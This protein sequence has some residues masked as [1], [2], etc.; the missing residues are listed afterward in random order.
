M[1]EYKKL[2]RT[3]LNR[4]AASLC[5]FGAIIILS[6]FILAS[7]ETARKESGDQEY[8]ITQ[9]HYGMDAREMERSVAIPLEDALS[10]IPGIN[11]IITFSENGRVRCYIRFRQ[12]MKSQR[13]YDA[14][15]EAAQRVYET[16]PPSAQRPELSSSNE[17]GIPVWMGALWDFPSSDFPDRIIKPVLE[18]IERIAEVEISGAGILEI[19]IAPDP[20]KIAALGISPYHLASSLQMNDGF[21]SGGVIRSDRELI[22]VTV[23][24]RYT[25]IDSLGEALIPINGGAIRLRDIARIIEAERES[26]TISRLDGKKTAI[27]SITASSG[28]NLSALSRRIKQKMDSLA[29]HDFEFKILLDRG[30]EETSTFRSVLFAALASSVL[31]ALTAFILIRKKGSSFFPGLI[32]A[33]SIPLISIISAAF[34]SRLGFPLDRKLLAGLSIGIGAAADAVL[35]SAHGFAGI[36]DFWNGRKTLAL[37]SIPLI[38]AAATTIAALFPLASFSQADELGSIAWALGAVTLVSMVISIAILPPLFIRANKHLSFSGVDK[39]ILF[40]SRITRLINRLLAKTVRSCYKKP[41]LVPGLAILITIVALVMLVNAGTDIAYLEAED[42]VYARVEFEGGFR[43]EEGDIRLA[44]WATALKDHD[45]ITAVQTSARLGSAQV[46]VNFDPRKLKSSQV[47]TLIRSLS[48]PRG[49]IYIPEATQEDRIWEIKIYGEDDALCRELVEK[50]AGLCSIVPLVHEVILNFK[51]GNPR[52]TL[53]PQRERYAESK[54]SFTAAA[55]M[56]RRSIHGP[57]IYKR[58]DEQGET[59]VRLRVSGFNDDLPFEYMPSIEDFMSLPLL[60]YNNNGTDV[61]RFDSLSSS[62]R[63]SEASVI[64]REDRRRVAS[65]SVRTQIIDPRR[66]REQTAAALEKMEL[67]PG[68]VIEFDPE[69]IRQAE[70]L[71]GTSFRFILALLFCYM[72]IAALNESFRFPL[73]VLSAVPVSLALPVVLIVLS[74]TPMNSA[75][76]CSLVA[77]SGMTVTASIIVC[78]EFWRANYRGNGS[79]SYYYTVLRRCLPVLLST[80][81]TTISAALPFL[82]LVEGGNSMLRSFSLVTIFG[83]AASLLCS[84]VLI[85]SL[86]II[87][88]KHRLG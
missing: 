88:K 10:L 60:A 78:G 64:R 29:I 61:I 30:A 32:C 74:G 20:E 51:D 11:N 24:N 27:I 31:V 35:I 54:I 37:I 44:S 75:I 49:F 25:D 69:A 48:I 73:L 65:F 4:P 34:L 84:L 21:F 62:I 80:G 16:L 87:L 5:I 70:A 56:I 7:G 39:K 63:G 38:S 36:L 79:P 28:T 53:V 67:P 81:V 9:R 26:D 83:V 17:S 85:P 41:L 40:I 59:D 8:M 52:L 47:R 66:V 58:I 46:L 13:G 33:A 50:A 23:D 1:A 22:P 42:S 68:Y 18:S 6:L 43:K 76:A 3:W 14:V 86:I 57:V 72:V 82:F 71:S 45:G 2:K 77:V 19:I 12:D 15:R 55:D